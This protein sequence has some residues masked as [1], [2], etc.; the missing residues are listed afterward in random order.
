MPKYKTNPNF[1]VNVDAQVAGDRLEQI[2]TRDGGKLK[3]ERVVADARP[4][5]SP[6]HDAFEWDDSQAAE[7]YRLDQAS[8]LIRSIT[9]IIEKSPNTKP[10]RAFVYFE[11]PGGES[12]YNSVV[13][14]LSHA[15]LQAEVLARA[16]K[17]AREWQQRYQDLEAL[18]GV[19]AAIE[20]VEKRTNG[21]E[22]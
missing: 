20:D 22:S 21:K 15:E 3:P 12:H 1:R 14:V 10:T 16:L 8:Y 5:K 6:L 9:V 7:R 19:F 17:E 2:R 13:E 18:A 11:R 4:K